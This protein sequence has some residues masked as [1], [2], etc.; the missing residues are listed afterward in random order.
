M[1]GFP[2]RNQVRNQE[3]IDAVLGEGAENALNVCL[4]KHEECKD[5]AK[6]ALR[7]LQCKVEL[8]MLWKGEIKAGNLEIDGSERKFVSAFKPT[9]D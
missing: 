4:E 1:I 2:V 3:L 8:K 5:E 6:A 9:Y 7:D